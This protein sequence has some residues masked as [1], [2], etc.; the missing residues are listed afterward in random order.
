ML[1]IGDPTSVAISSA[2]AFNNK[3]GDFVSAIYH[4]H[5]I[6]ITVL[7][8]PVRSAL[9]SSSFYRGGNLNS[10]RLVLCSRINRL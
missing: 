8:S 6:L 4:E 2:A 7:D 9:L 10:E 1:E 3:H 5:I